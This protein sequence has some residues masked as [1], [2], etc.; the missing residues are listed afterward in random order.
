MGSSDFYTKN[1]KYDYSFEN[2]NQASNASFKKQRS[3][4]SDKYK[5][6]EKIYESLS[7]D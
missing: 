7:K 1:L 4:L 6:L 3:L 2:S 5:K